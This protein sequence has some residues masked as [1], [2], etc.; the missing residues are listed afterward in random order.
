M[1]LRFPLFFAPRTNRQIKM[2]III[3][4]DISIKAKNTM[5]SM[6]F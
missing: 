4:R 1:L 2:I 5:R 3:I 6:V